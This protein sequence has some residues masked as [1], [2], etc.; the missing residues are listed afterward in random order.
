M[1]IYTKIYQQL[2][3]LGVVAVLGAGVGNSVSTVVGYKNL[4]FERLPATIEGSQRFR[5]ACY[6]TQ[7]G[8][9]NIEQA[10]AV[11][12]YPDAKTAEALSLQQAKP[13]LFQEVY[14]DRGAVNVALKRQLNGYL[15]Y[16]LRTCIDQR[17]RF[18]IR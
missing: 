2:E 17:H 13:A 8:M 7:R 15:S 10:M 5:L 18:G 3:T 11:L 9:V 16:W 1:T 6:M 12:V 4:S 14:P